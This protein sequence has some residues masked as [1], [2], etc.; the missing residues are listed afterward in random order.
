MAMISPE[1]RLITRFLSEMYLGHA[2]DL[3][4]ALLGIDLTILGHANPIE[5]SS[6][7][8][9]TGQRNFRSFRIANLVLAPGLPSIIANKA[10]LP[11]VIHLSVKSLARS[12]C[13]I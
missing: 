13:A 6:C 5:V 7:K 12:D 4:K 2:F 8:L 10:F 9:S 11:A 1:E 3:G